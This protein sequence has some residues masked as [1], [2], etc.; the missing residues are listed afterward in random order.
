[1]DGV[2]VNY[3]AQM[4]VLKQ[5]N[6]KI[7]YPAHKLVQISTKATVELV[8]ATWNSEADIIQLGK[9]HPMNGMAGLIARYVKNKL[10]FL[11]C[12]DFEMANIHFGANWQKVGVRYFESML[13]CRVDFVS[14]HTTF[15]QNMVLK[16]GVDPKRVIYLP[17]GADGKRFSN[18][19]KTK[20]EE[21]RAKTGLIG[22][23]VIVYIGSL[24]MPSHP[25]DILLDAF[26]QVHTANPQ[27]ILL[28]VGGGEE[29]ERL[30][31]RARWLGLE[32][33]II[34][35]GRVPGVEVP[36]YYYL[37]DISTEPVI[38]NQVGRSSLPLKMFESWVAGVPFVTQDVGDRRMVMG[39]PPA[40]LV[41]KAGDPNSLADAIIRILADPELA[42]SLRKRGFEQAE[43][44]SWEN[45]AKKMEAI[46]YNAVIGKYGN[47]I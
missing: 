20:V 30:V 32:N 7:Y 31:T 37:A 23:K 25:V 34:F 16:M 4:H 22:K 14:V 21:I 26:L 18:I 40:G 47:T 41:A 19:D 1:M 5:N 35:Q 27:S 15:L 12:D 33:S 2:D 45:L 6:Q 24:S 29:Y 28:I 46:Y 13:P 36:N 9:P 11:D 10:V 17:H 43:K 8:K 42:L 38:E 3:V 44:Y 39:D